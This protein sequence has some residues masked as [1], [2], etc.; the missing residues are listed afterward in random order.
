MLRVE[1]DSAVFGFEQQ[2]EIH[3]RDP[4]DTR[5]RNEPRDVS[6]VHVSVG[7]CSR[8]HAWYTYYSYAYKRYVWLHV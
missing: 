3:S 8:G 5:Y 7:V 4:N 6:V 2:H 1:Q